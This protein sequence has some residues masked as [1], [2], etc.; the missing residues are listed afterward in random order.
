MSGSA[1]ENIL[2]DKHFQAKRYYY[3]GD[4]LEY[5]CRH[6]HINAAESDPGWWVWKLTWSGGNLQKTE[7][8]LK[9]AASDR[10]SLGWP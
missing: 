10:A 6:E 8:P 2:A 4:D 7:G 3:S 9:G 1:T 5:I